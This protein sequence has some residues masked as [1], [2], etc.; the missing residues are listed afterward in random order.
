[1]DE[2]FLL[3][4]DVDKGSIERRK[5]LLHFPEI[6]ISDGKAVPLAGLLVQFNQPVVFHQRDVNVSRCDID[7]QILF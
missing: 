5:N 6:D 4:S 2:C 3:V 1:M 7:D